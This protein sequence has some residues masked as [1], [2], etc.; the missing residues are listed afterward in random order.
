MTNRKK[1]IELVF[2][3]IEIKE[4]KNSKFIS[5]EHGQ[6]IINQFAANIDDIASWFNQYDIGSIELWISG[7]IETDGLLRLALS[8]KGEGGMKITLKPKNIK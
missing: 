8:A 3:Q 5:D 6:K 2:P 7:G 4:E 1:K